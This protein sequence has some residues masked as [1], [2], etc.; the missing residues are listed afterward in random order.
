MSPAKSRTAPF[1]ES[2]LVMDSVEVVDGMVSPVFHFP[3]RLSADFHFFLNPEI[4]ADFPLRNPV[5][6]GMSCRVLSP[7][8][9]PRRCSLC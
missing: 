7:L 6:Y 9:A 3:K 2:F 8:F 4:G 1:A 5:I